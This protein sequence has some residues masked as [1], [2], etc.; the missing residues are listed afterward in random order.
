MIS[1]FLIHCL[2]LNGMTL[3]VARI[4]IAKKR[5][6]EKTKLVKMPFVTKIE[7]ESQKGGESQKQVSIS[8]K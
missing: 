1:E 7:F 2:H 4:N 8:I 5:R 3:K 6:Y